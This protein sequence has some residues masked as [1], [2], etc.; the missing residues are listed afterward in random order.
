MNESHI[1]S[2]KM[3]LDADDDSVKG[4]FGVAT[5]KAAFCDCGAA[6]RGVA[7]RGEVRQSAARRECWKFADDTAPHVQWCIWHTSWEKDGENFCVI[8]R[9]AAAA[10]V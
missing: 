7:R 10:I 4:R 8:L 2:I 9:A 5:W 3:R 1:L 6:K